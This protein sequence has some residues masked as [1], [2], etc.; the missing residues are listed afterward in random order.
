MSGTLD[1]LRGAR[2]ELRDCEP[3]DALTLRRAI[4]DALAPAPPRGEP[5]L[6]Q[7]RAEDYGHTADRIDQVRADL[8]A[9]GTE[10][11]PR[12][13]RGAVAET[14]AQA[15]LALSEESDRTRGT[16]LR[17]G[18]TLADWADA[19]DQAQRLDRQG[20][21]L[22]ED[23]EQQAAAPLP[24]IG[25]R[26]TALDGVNARI[27]AAEAAEQH[28]TATASMLRQLAAQARAERV[29]P[30]AADPLDAVELANTRDPGGPK[31][32]DGEILTP[33]QLERGSSRL[34]GLSPADQRRFRALL[35][36]AKSPQEAAYLWKALAAGHDLDRIE[37]FDR[38]I[39]SKGDDPRWLSQHLNP[40]FETAANRKEDGQRHDLRYG[41]QTRHTQ[42][43]GDK[44]YDQGHDG[45]CVPAATVVA[46]AKVDPVTMLDLTTGG[47]AH[48]DD[49]AAAFQHRLQTRYVNDYHHGQ[50]ADGN[51][52][53]NPHTHRN[54]TGT[55]D[56]GTHALADRD[57]GGDYRSVPLAGEADRRAALPRIEQAADEG[58]PVMMS[59]KS[60]TEGHEVAV[61]GHD[62][63]RLEVYNPWGFTTWVT[64][65]QFV[66]S[67]LG[68]LTRTPKKNHDLNRSDEVEVPE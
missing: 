66:H 14:A 38:A 11:L 20:V 6:I 39:H 16:L 40:Q 23:A 42:G 59:L 25:T 9:V 2:F 47:T 30:S 13:W 55:F 29:D 19:L 43:M 62:G 24:P 57:L 45:A 44:Y 63:N 50:D 36:H 49:S 7:R 41:G 35:A 17:A 3:T 51:P 52:H 65:D 56:P 54:D 15:V 61:I 27:G 32:G 12:A 31:A 10:G 4:A 64:E 68:E 60:D 34:D 26:Q 5:E 28:G 8:R 37:K 33:Y 22:L 21:G 48:G 1:R 53:Y 58:R 46:Q 18:R 67:D